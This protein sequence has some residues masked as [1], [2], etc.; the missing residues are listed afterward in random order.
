MVITERKRRKGRSRFVEGV[1]LVTRKII[2]RMT[3]NIDKS[4]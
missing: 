1:S 3:A 4:D 2:R